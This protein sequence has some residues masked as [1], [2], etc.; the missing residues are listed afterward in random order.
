[1]SAD[2]QNALRLREFLEGSVC[3]IV[4]PSSSFTMT[5]QA[6]LS[7][8]GI[9]LAQILTAKRIEE[10]KRIVNEMRPKLIITEYDVPPGMGLELIEMQ[11][12]QRSPNDRIAIVATRNSSDSAV[13]EAAEGAVDAFI[14]KPFSVDTFRKKLLET[15]ERKMSPTAYDLKIEDGRQHIVKK[16]LDQ[17]LEKFYEAKP[18]DPR[19]TLACFMAGQTLQMQ[20][21]FEEALSE[22]REGRRFQPLHYKC[23]IGEFESLM[24]QKQYAEAYQLV[25]TI[26][27][28]YPLTSHRLG[29]IFIAAVFTYHFDELAEYYEL[30]LQLETRTPW[31]T[32]LTSLALFTAGKYWVQKNEIQKAVQYFDMGL[33]VRGRELSFLEM[34]EEE[35]L[36][37]GAVSE[38]DALLTKA[39]PSD[40]GSPVHSRLRFRIDGLMLPPSSVIERGRKLVNE[41]LA[42]PE[43]YRLLV[44]LIVQE[45]KATLAETIITKAVQEHPDMR[46]ELYGLL[47]QIPSE[48]A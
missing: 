4:E 23:L 41:G 31:L 34:I 48:S 40:I 26:R 32:E 43:I 37:V 14:L 18:M 10:A 2:D 3:L 36:R 44:T 12:G 13:A 29:Q 16:E 9:P 21:R 45:K 33:T 30:Y 6:C 15:F 38:A 17:A 46:N 28:N 27:S 35:L 11:E 47:Q 20:G 24:E 7:E 25:G 42:T 39:L 1:M 19:P 5:L 8:F 22:F